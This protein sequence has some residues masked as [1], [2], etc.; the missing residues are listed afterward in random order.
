MYS[1]SCRANDTETVSYLCVTHYIL[2]VV[3]AFAAGA[4]GAKGQQG[5]TGA[6]GRRNN[7]QNTGASTTPPIP[8]GPC[9]GPVG[10]HARTLTLTTT[11]YRTAIEQFV[12]INYFKV[13]LINVW[14]FV[15]TIHL[16]YLFMHLI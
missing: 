16:I 10:K 7:V 6:A 1:H 14:A 5:A 4:T 15:L 9:S 11:V 8:V 2:R 3:I 12:Y 13:G